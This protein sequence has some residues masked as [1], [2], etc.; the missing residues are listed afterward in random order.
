MANSKSKLRCACALLAGLGLFCF[1]QSLADAQQQASG[2]AVERFYQ[3]APGG[4]W[5]VMDDLDFSGRLGGVVSL[6]SGYA[7]NPLVITGPNGKQKLAVVSEEAF[8]DIG[9]A[10]T[11]DRFRGYLNFPMPLLVSGT[12][13][14]LGPYQF[15]APSVSLGTNPDTISDGRIGFDARLFG[16]PGS[17][18][19]LGAGTQLI[20]PSGSHAD[21]VTDGTYRGMIRFLAAGDAGSFTYAG[22]L[23]V[24]VRPLNYAPV[25]GSPNGSEFLYGISGGRRV[26]GPS[27]WAVIAGP[28]IFGETAFHQFFSGETGTEALLTGRLEHS[29]TGRSLR[30]K[31]GVGH[32]LVQNFGAAQWRIVFGVELFGHK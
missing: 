19:R 26:L 12:S 4:G 6:S 5:F 1:R 27:G 24:H 13:G 14:T 28:E 7:R 3:S 22:Q 25:P 17:S 16:K 31:L 21:Y 32:A 20:F 23:G 9:G 2:F 15:T 18:L 11:H 8:V 10:V 29:G 30:I